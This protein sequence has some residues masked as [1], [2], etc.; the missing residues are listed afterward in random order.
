MLHPYAIIFDLSIVCWGV[1]ALVAL[2]IYSN[3]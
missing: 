3:L 2:S 1:V